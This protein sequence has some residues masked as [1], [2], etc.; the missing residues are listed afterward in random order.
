[1]VKARPQAGPVQAPYCVESATAVERIDSAHGTFRRD[2]LYRLEKELFV[3]LTMRGSKGAKLAAAVANK[4]LSLNDFRFT[5]AAAK[6]R[7]SQL[8]VAIRARV[9]APARAQDATATPAVT[10]LT[11]ASY[12]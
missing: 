10:A 2:W 9:G 11:P 8:R 7:P 1:M 4:P 6:G 5:P 12:N 3:L